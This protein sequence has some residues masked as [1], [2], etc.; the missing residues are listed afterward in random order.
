MAKLISENDVK[1]NIIAINFFDE[2]DQIDQDED[3]QKESQNQFLTKQ[4]YH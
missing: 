2:I 3:Q 4:F 1:V